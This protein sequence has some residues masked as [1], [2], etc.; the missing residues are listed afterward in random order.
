MMND[1][2]LS[3][4]LRVIVFDHLP[5]LEHKNKQLKNFCETN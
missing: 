3:D 5:V 2:E 4:E 1:Q